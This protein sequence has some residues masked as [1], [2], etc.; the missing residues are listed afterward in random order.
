MPLANF[1][2]LQIRSTN[3]NDL[4]EK[5]TVTVTLHRLQ[6]PDR[7]FRE[8]LWEEPDQFLYSEAAYRQLFPYDVYKNEN[9]PV[10]W[11]KEKSLQ[12]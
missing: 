11:K 9:L 5:T 2:N 12:T 6:Q 4:F 7:L 10:N 8:R 1:K 3:L